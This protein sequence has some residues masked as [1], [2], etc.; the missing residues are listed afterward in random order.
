[1]ADF[2]ALAPS[3][4]RAK[5][6]W[7]EAQTLANHYDA[8]AGSFASNGHDLIELVK[9]FIECVCITILGEFGRP[10][11]A[12]DPS[13]TQLFV[14]SLSAL[15]LENTRGVS[16]F[17]KVLSAYN[18]L[19]DALGEMRNENGPVAHGK[20]GFLDA[21]TFNHRRV[22]LLAADTVL[23]LLVNALDGKEPDLR[24]TREPYERFDRLHKKIDYSVAVESSIEDEDDFPIIVL[25]IRTEGLPEGM[26]LRVEPSR[27]LY[28]IDRQA[29][30][31]LLASAEIEI[32]TI[33]VT[34]NQ[35]PAIE[36]VSETVRPPQET[37]PTIEVVMAYEG[38]LA[39]LKGEL[40]QYVRALGLTRIS[41]SAADSSL[42]DSLLATADQNMGTDWKSRDTL[43]A[44]LK[45][46]LRRT[47]VQFGLESKIAG[48]RAEQL[49]EWF[50]V[51]VPEAQNNDNLP[52]T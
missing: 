23:D 50:K 49:V 37:H 44:Q 33:S 9:S 5:E 28:S 51:K 45:V 16:K 17:D 22:F 34:G 48:E 27:L 2:D 46:A 43:Q 19:T 4:R 29:Y 40:T 12:A 21:L 38:I 36:S 31:D 20:D 32:P 24:Y 6:R 18:R 15:G 1:M 41:D 13:T 35:E 10:M 8:V 11:P 52:V 14:A 25:S 47:L 3:F 7:P 26:K 39:P 42:I 30:V